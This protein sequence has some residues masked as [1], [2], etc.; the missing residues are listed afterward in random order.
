M[1]ERL[2]LGSAHK[3]VL[4]N[5]IREPLLVL[6]EARFGGGCEREPVV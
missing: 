1:R 2:S 4:R 3:L 6:P 5:R